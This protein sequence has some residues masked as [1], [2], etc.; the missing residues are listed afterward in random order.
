MCGIVGIIAKDD[1]GFYA[2]ADDIF[3]ELLYADGVRGMDSTGVFLTTKK[4]QVQ[5]L[6][7]AVNPGIFTGTA[8]WKGM[9]EQINKKARIVIG[10]NRKATHGE[11]VS[12]NAHPFVKE[13]GEGKDK[14][15]IILVHNGFISNHKEL[16]ADV[17]VDSEA[18]A[19]T[20]L[21]HEDPV[22]A[23]EKLS[24][25]WALVWYNWGTKKLYLARNDQRPLHL[26]EYGSILYLASEEDML[27]WVLKRK[28]NH[29]DGEIKSIKPYTMLEM[30]WHP[31]F[32]VTAKDIPHKVWSPVGPVGAA[33][34]NHHQYGG[35]WESEM[36]FHQEMQDELEEEQSA[37]SVDE[38]NVSADAEF[39]LEGEPLPE[40][41]NLQQQA[42]QTDEVV[43]LHCTQ[44]MRLY[45]QGSQVLFKP[46]KVSFSDATFKTIEGVI[47]VPSKSMQHARWRVKKEL[48]TSWLWN[49]GAPHMGVVQFVMRRD[50]DIW[51]QLE[52][53]GQTEV[54]ETFNG[55]KLAKEEWLAVCNENRCVECASDLKPHQAD[56]T[57]VNKPSIH[58]YVCVCADC[59]TKKTEPRVVNAE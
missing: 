47:W 28:K 23:L 3:E 25:A 49:S 11:V 34:Y 33:R 16:D 9:K 52:T 2:D 7:Q 14:Q 5:V 24:G 15:S 30:T 13:K 51:V 21:E 57:E 26:T 38:H 35:F 48:D 42:A 58:R 19:T 32:D 27:R 20:L 41:K 44:L 39:V 10:H 12:K 8:S 37:C 56:F 31:K 50:K 1:F 46:E 54:V 55:E 4:N 53:V 6:K 17:S 18:I 40:L 59:V 36:A 29:F 43:E 45:P 22:K